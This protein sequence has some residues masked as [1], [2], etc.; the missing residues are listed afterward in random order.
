MEKD[1]FMLIY[2][3]AKVYRFEC[4]SQAT[5]FANTH[6]RGKYEF[7]VIIDTVENQVVSKWSY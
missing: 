1:R 3:D 4:L 2:K 7:Y 5:S 6:C